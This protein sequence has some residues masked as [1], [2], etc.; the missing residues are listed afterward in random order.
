MTSTIVFNITCDVF[1]GKWRMAILYS[2]QR[3]PMRFSEIKECCPGCS[4]KVL[5]SVLKE[6]TVNNLLVRRQ[7]QTIPV[8]VTYELHPNAYI[9]VRD[10]HIFY[11][12]SCAYIVKNAEA[13]HLEPYL[14]EQIRREI[15]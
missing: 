2:L 5:S 12:A 4:V 14:I 9:I 15:R 13:L 11:K 3:G 8:R 7:Y 1:G 10:L 6:L